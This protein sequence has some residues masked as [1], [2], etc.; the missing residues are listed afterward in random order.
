[1]AD[2][3]FQV[4]ALATRLRQKIADESLTIAAVKTYA[5]A[6]L[7]ALLAR[8]EVVSITMEGGS[9]AAVLTCHPAIV[10]A[11]CNEI[12]AEEDAE[13]VSSGVTHLDMSG[14]RIES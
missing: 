4:A 11:A 3:S 5:D 14:N 8:T 13:L 10:L 2:D 9:S 1:M 6:A 12:I 7:T